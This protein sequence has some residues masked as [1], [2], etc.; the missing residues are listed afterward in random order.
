MLITLVLL[1]ATYTSFAQKLFFNKINYTDSVAFEKNIVPLAAELAAQYIKEPNFSYDN[2][3]RI[4]I[5]A[6]QYQNAL[7]SLKKVGALR[8]QD[9]VKGFYIGFGFQ[10]LLHTLLRGSTQ[11][12]FATIYN[13][14]FPELYNSLNEGDKAS[15]SSYFNSDIASLKKAVQS[16]CDELKNQDSINTG[17]AIA[18][19][20]A[21]V[22]Y[23]IYNRIQPLAKNILK[24]L[25]DEKF[26]IQDSVLIKMPD[27]ALIA[28]C[29]VRDKKN[30]TPQP[31]V[32]MYNIYAGREVG[33]CKTALA[34]GFTG[35]VVNTRGKR[36]SL[37][38]IE[39]FEHD[40]ADAY[41]IID[42]ISKQAWCNGKIGMYGGSYLGFAQWSATKKMHP[43]LKTI[44]PQVAVGIGI[45]Y[46][47]HN[48]VFMSYMLRWIHYVTNNKLIDEAEF[49]DTEKWNKVYTK[50]YTSGKAFS[51]LDSFDGRPN[52]IFQRW[53]QHPSYDGYWQN[54]VPYGKEFANINIPV[55]TTTGY[56]DA[57]QRGAFYYYNQH[58][59]WNKNANHYLLIGPWDHAGAQ[60]SA[61]LVT[62]GYKIDSV[63]N[64]NINTTVWQWFKYILKDS[65]KPAILKDKVNYQVMGANTW[66]HASSIYNAAPKTLEFTLSNVYQKKGFMLTTTKPTT[67]KY[68]EHEISYTDRTD[69][70]NANYATVDSA[71][72]QMN[73]LSF[74]SDP[75]QKDIVITGSFTGQL[76]A[77][78]NK[79]DVDLS[80]TLYEQE[81][82]GK[83]F[84]LSNTI[85]R[86]SF[87]KDR[88]KRILL[89]P[90]VEETI[91]I[92]N[93]YFTSKKL[94]KGSRII[95]TVGMN[96]TK[97]W[98][99]NYG[100]GKDVSTET[101]ED[102][103]IPLRIQ[104]SNES[105]ISL[106]IEL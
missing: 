77:I 100:T 26:I 15:A 42:W 60:S 103:K 9:T 21:Y 31:V 99:I 106:P 59:Y 95:L 80:I 39:P 101:I 10:S 87:L 22:S 63:A 7:H 57:D 82:N 89:T 5:V 45:D 83:Y 8:G 92:G 64:I 51:K 34:N 48:G 104:W 47:M 79:K 29:I 70:I 17:Q 81:P 35:V 46:P 20:R 19:C 98:Q 86:A 24:N 1:I 23:T 11:K 96:K 14:V 58:H 40:G 69:T 97:G 16:K 13:E 52:A 105:Y 27:G 54:M 49:N 67:K 61:S 53:L 76:K 4:E 93:S 44:V 68:I 2:L 65:S 102:G 36:L 37:D 50:W 12:S 55:L 73:K 71:F 78:F 85:V 94:S 84:I 90:R 41:H 56:F 74:I 62:N 75:L 18:L 91:E 32:I 43:A 72:E 88:T 3:F 33:I 30:T 28:T 38:S 25:D 66:K 6:Q